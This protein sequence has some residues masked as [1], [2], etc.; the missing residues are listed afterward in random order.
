MTYSEG[1]IV[2][3]LNEATK[4]GQSRKLQSPWRGP[5]LVVSAD[6]PLYTVVDQKERRSTLHHDKLK[7]CHD[8]E[9][10]LW[11]RRLRNKYFE[12]IESS[13]DGDNEENTLI[14]TEDILEDSSE[15]D[16]TVTETNDQNIVDGIEKIQDSE[17]TATT[18]AGRKTKKPAHLEEYV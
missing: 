8:R 5:Y 17:S 16:D 9:L 18:R 4:V 14:G 7:R 1:D 6:P 11:I 13:S 3:R 2:Y 15:A 12:E 10:P